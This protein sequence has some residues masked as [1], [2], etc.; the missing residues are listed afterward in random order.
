MMWITNAQPLHPRIAREMVEAE[1]ARKDPKTINWQA[2][3]MI[4]FEQAQ[5]QEDDNNAEVQR[6]D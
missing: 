1:I 4:A 5:K 6:Q 2:I 3:T